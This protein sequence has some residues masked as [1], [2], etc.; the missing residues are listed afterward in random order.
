MYVLTLGR[1]KPEQIQRRNETSQRNK[2]AMVSWGRS[3]R[4]RVTNHKILFVPKHEVRGVGIIGAVWLVNNKFVFLFV[5]V[6]PVGRKN[7]EG[8]NDK[9]QMPRKAKSG[10]EPRSMGRG[11][12]NGVHFR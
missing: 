9:K 8:K 3:F 5:V 7:A 10:S 6:I 12:T 4:G 2:D 1:I 11:E